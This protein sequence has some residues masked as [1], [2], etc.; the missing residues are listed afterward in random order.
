MALNVPYGTLTTSKAGNGN[1]MQT[2]TMLKNLPQ[3]HVC[4]THFW[5]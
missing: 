3:Q 5:R 4:C 2:I 1:V